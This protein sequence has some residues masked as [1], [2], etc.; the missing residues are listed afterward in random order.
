MDYPTFL[1]GWETVERIGKGGFSIVYKI[2]QADEIL[3]D[4][5]SALKV[6]EIPHDED[7]YRHYELEGYD[8]ASIK[9]IFKAQV[10]NIVA[11][12]EIISATTKL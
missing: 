6:I 7:E 11:E 10:N 5:Y 12:S 2:K 4:V 9:T 3:G 1:P 8:D